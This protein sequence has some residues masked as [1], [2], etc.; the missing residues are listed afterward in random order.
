MTKWSMWYVTLWVG[1]PHPKSP[2]PKFGVHRP[3]ESGDIMF[4]VLSRDRDIEESRD[5]VGGVLSS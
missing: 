2:P 1:F 4:F 3:C 5:F